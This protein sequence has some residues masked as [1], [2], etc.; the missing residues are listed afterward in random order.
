MDIFWQQIM[1]VV[2]VGLS[3]FYLVYRHIRR[4]RKN[5][6]CANCPTLKTLQ[7]RAELKSK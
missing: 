7:H 2:A 3:V 5:S 6:G 1:I 4:R